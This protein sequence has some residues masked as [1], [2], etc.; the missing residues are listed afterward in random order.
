VKDDNADRTAGDGERLGTDEDR[1]W[2]AS[3]VAGR[4]REVLEQVVSDP[5]ADEPERRS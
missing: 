5:R 2:H 4:P 3:I 1:G